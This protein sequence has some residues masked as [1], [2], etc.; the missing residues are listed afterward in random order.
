MAR[1]SSTFIGALR[2][3]DMTDQH[4]EDAL[5]ARLVKRLVRSGFNEGSFLPSISIS[6]C[7]P[8]GSPVLK[9]TMV[10]SGTPQCGSAPTPS[11]LNLYTSISMLR[12]AHMRLRGKRLRHCI[13][14]VTE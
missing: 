1:A 12:R 9:N 11:H 2:E 3:R 14:S 6:V 4:G 5:P 10:E 13:A 8:S 7:L